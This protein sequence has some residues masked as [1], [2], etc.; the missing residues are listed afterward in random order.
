MESVAEATVIKWVK[1]PGD[2]IETDEAVMEIAT[3][4]VDSEVP[5]PVSGKLVEQLC[6]EDD[7]VQVGAVIAVIET[8]EPA[9]ETPVAE[10]K[11]AAEPE[12][13]QEPELVAVEAQ[14]QTPVAPA[15]AEPVPQESDEPVVKH[16]EPTIPSAEPVIQHFDAIPGIDLL[17]SPGL[18]SGFKSAAT[19][20]RFYSPLV[21]SI[22]MQENV[23][24]EELDSIPGT[25]LEGRLTKDDLIHF[26]QQRYM[27]PPVAKEAAQPEQP[28]QP[29]H[30]P[31]PAAQPLVEAPV[32]AQHEPEQTTTH[33]HAPETVI[34][35]LEIPV[36]ATAEV[37][38]PEPAA[39][40]PEEPETPGDRT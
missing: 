32:A 31:L 26:I 18:S 33:A 20:G 40:Q 21:K 10:E 9:A 13:V 2:Y 14:E 17:P 36:M 39:T 28:A 8:E 11:P 7:V 38:K 19:S 5:S 34:P 35:E 25:G 27:R 24:I 4:K 6:K 29:A 22:A 37:E 1:K 15:A 12:P 30:E 3:D 23:T 16:E